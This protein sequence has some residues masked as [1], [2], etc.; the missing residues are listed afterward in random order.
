MKRTTLAASLLLAAP[1]AAQSPAVLV[2]GGDVVSGVGSVVSVEQ[3]AIRSATSWLVQVETD[4]PIPWTT[5][6]VLR[7]GTPYVRQGDPVSA[8]RRAPRC[9]RSSIRRSTRPGRRAGR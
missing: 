9:W 5:A 4:S 6:V 2:R 1:A 7:I 3:I 8:R